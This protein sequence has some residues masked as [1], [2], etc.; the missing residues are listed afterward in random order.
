M[1]KITDDIIKLTNLSLS[2]GQQ[3]RINHSKI[4]PL[5]PIECARIMQSIKDETGESNS[6][7]AKRLNLGKPKSISG[8]ILTDI[9]VEKPGT[10]MVL[11]FLQLLE[12]SKKSVGLIGFKGQDKPITFS[13]VAILHKLPL[14]EQDQIISAVVKD[15]LSR[16]DVRDILNYRK[17]NKCELKSAIEY[18]T[19]EKVPTAIHYQLAYNIPKNVMVILKN[20][21]DSTD[22]I[23]KKLIKIIHAKLKL[24]CESIS[25]YDE[26]MIIT[27]NEELHSLFEKEMEIKNLT[28]NECIEKLLVDENY[29]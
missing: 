14:D 8:K 7:I 29:G 28:Y 1:T 25:I 23:E 22:E 12:I 20:L 16:D 27:M 17:K 5:Y 4:R 18:I 3:G 15:K 9:H 11:K 13:T 19:N 24:R 2:V 21:S 26:V 10:S 6:D